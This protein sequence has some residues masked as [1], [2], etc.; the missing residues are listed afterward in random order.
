MR[1]VVIGDIHG[2]LAALDTLLDTIAPTSEDVIV[3]LGDY[4][5][6]GPDSRGVI[7]RLIQVSNHCTLFPLMGNHEEMML[8]S[9]QGGVSPFRWLQNGGTETMESYGFTGDVDVIPK[10]HFDFLS[11]LLPYKELDQF[12]CLHANYDSDVPLTDQTPAYL[13][14][15]K[16]TESFP[17]PN[18]EVKRLIVGHTPA[19][20]GEVVFHPHLIALDTF[21]YGG[22]WLSALDLSTMEVYQAD[23][24]G[25]LRR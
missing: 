8:M 24:E 21:C 18:P 15:I 13:R 16:L 10:E 22:G 1:T 11:N 4:I 14:W 7:E 9:L 25:R 19:R 12:L 23:I 6:R 5:D 3:T 17:Q 2:C 20:D